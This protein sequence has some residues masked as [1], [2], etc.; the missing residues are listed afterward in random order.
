MR[1]YDAIISFGSSIF[2]KLEIWTEMDFSL[3]WPSIAFQIEGGPQNYH[4]NNHLR[5]QFRII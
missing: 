2:V 5:S 3:L 4:V 1:F